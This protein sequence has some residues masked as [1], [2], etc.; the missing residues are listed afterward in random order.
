MKVR[1]GARL[2]YTLE[3]PEELGTVSVPPMLLQPL[4]ENAIKHGIEPSVDGG[5]ITIRATRDGSMLELTV[6]D[7]GLGLDAPPQ[8]GTR[9]GNTN[10]RERLKVLYDGRAS[11][12]L[13]PNTPQGALA[14]IRLPL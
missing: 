10:L 1:M 2:A 13:I 14:S 8:D 7:T 11:F 4:V 12:E 6:A 9:V 5:H 3:L